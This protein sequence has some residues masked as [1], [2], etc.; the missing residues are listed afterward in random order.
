MRLLEEK[1]RNE[2]RLL[3]GNVVK[4]DMFLNHQLDVTLLNEMGKEF[5]RLFQKENITKIVTVEAS[6]IAIACMAA[7]HFHVPVVFA[8]KVESLNIG[9][10]VYSSEVFSFTKQKTYKIRVSQDYL[11]PDDCVLIVDDFLASGSAL[12]G[13]IDIVKQAGARVGGVGIAIEKGFQEGGQKIRSQ[14]VRLESLAIIE[15]MDDQQ[16]IFR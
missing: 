11:S 3:S 12:T 1:I 13:L 16:I 15:S 4:V 7:Q 9:Q 14:G 8:K 6:G 2:G 5:Y 10:N